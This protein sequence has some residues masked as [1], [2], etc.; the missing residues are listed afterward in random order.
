LIDDPKT[1]QYL[2]N[3]KDIDRIFSVFT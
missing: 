2:R 3:Y 1:R